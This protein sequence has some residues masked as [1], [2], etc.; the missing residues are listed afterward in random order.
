MKHELDRDETA[1][2]AYLAAAWRAP[3]EE[4]E[5]PVAEETVRRA[6]EALRREK[7]ARQ[8]R[9]WR[10]SVAVATAAACAALLA[11]AAWPGRNGT[12]GIATAAED[13]GGETA[14]TTLAEAR[15]APLSEAFEGLE[16][17]LTELA[18]ADFESGWGNGWE[19]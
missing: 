7:A 1:W 12:D 17:M 14:E 16:T 5:C 9:T 4:T 13:T 6:D 2:E 10:W 8:V 3:G 11:W 18:S 19:M 15:E